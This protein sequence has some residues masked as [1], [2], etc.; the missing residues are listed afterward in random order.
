MERLT[1]GLNKIKPTHKKT[2]RFNRSVFYFYKQVFEPN[3]AHKFE[4]YTSSCTNFST[5]A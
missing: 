2:L 5:L 3:Y 1:S 4:G